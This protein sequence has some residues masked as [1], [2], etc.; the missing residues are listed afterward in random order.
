MRLITPAKPHLITDGLMAQ[1]MLADIER[2]DAM[3]GGMMGLD[4]FRGKQV[5]TSGA[6]Y[7]DSVIS[8]VIGDLDATVSDSYDGT[9]QI[10][11]NVI[12]SPADSSAQADNDYFLG[13]DGTSSTDDP[14]F[15]GSA[16][17]ASAYFLYDGGD[18]F[19]LDNANTA[20]LS[21]LHKTNET[22]LEFW[23]CMAVYWP[24]GTSGAFN[25]F[26]TAQSSSNHGLIIQLQQGASNRVRI[27]QDSGSAS[28]TSTGTV[29]MSTDAWNILLVSYQKTSGTGGNYKV[30]H[31]SATVL[32]S[33]TLSTWNT[34]TTDATFNARIGPGTGAALIP[35]G[36]RLA[37]FSYG[38]EYLDDTKAGN[39]I[40][41]LETR[42]SRDYTP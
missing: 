12:T 30:W 29:N 8:S 17:S 16:G 41:H 9:S 19:A 15:T 11:L 10:W 22:A 3:R 27:I 18:K 21:K 36:V 14:T 35:N 42:H 40:S 34:T 39:I 25:L 38:N 31:N 1:R 13:L 23:M 24:S 37:N 33:G 2:K 26:G 4:G 6:S 7:L 32:T 20:F 5:P 28:I